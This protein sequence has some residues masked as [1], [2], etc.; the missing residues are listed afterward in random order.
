MYRNEELYSATAA[1]YHAAPALV[2]RHV[3]VTL[4]PLLFTAC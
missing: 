1:A 3:P 2:T 4:L